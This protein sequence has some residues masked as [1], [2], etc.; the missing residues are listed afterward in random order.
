MGIAQAVNSAQLVL[1]WRVG[2]RILTDVLRSKRGTYGEEI[3]ATVSRQLT[4]DYGRGFAEPGERA[5]PSG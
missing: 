2:E 1:Y 3:V 4:A 5:S